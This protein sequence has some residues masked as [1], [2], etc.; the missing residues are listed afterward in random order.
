MFKGVISDDRGVGYVVSH[1]LKNDLKGG[2]DLPCI[3]C[4]ALRRSVSHGLGSGVKGII[5]L[6]PEALFLIQAEPDV[7]DEPAFF[8]V[9]FFV[10]GLD[11]GGVPELFRNAVKVVGVK[12]D[13]GPVLFEAL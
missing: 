3:P 2:V 4:E 12:E 11:R 9:A 1:W 7:F 10:G 6:P 13:I 5:P 8:D